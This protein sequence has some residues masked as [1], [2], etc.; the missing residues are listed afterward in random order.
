[1]YVYPER[2][3]VGDFEVSWYFFIFLLTQGDQIG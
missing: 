1:M 3:L 2:L